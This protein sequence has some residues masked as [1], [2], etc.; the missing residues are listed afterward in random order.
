MTKID[1][2][3]FSREETFDFGLNVEK[4]GQQWGSWGRAGGGG[5]VLSREL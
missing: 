4:T 1:W 5:D 2:T 3:S